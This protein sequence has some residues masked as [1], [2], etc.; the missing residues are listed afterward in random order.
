MKT[1]PQYNTTMRITSLVMVVNAKVNTLT[2][3]PSAK[4][5]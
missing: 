2:V 3:D 4:K 5:A 1:Q